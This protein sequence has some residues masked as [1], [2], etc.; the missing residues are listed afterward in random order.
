MIRTDLCCESCVRLPDSR[1]AILH[2]K[3]KIMIK[4]LVSLS[5]LGLACSGYTVAYAQVNSADVNIVFVRAE[6]ADDRFVCTTEI[7][8]RNDDDS[9]D[10]HVIVLLPLEV[11]IIEMTVLQG[12]GSCKRSGPR[13]EDHGYA[14][15]HLGQLPQGQDVRRTVT[16]TTTKS[17]VAA[18]YP[19]T[20]A[21]FIYGRVG[22]I[23]KINNYA[24]ASAP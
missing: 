7:N 2:I 9:F 19:Q 5:L 23:E 6:V 21:A 4:R 17:A 14:T 24:T 13:E 15:C 11:K 18:N 20:C 1:S 3:G 22:D 10:T 8:N 16:I 12:P